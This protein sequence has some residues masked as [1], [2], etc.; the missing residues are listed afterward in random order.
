MKFILKSSLWKRC[1]LYPLKPTLNLPCFGLG[2]T[3][4]VF[5]SFKGQQSH[6]S[7]S[8]KSPF[9]PFHDVA[10]EIT[11]NAE[12]I[13][14]ELHESRAIRDMIINIFC[15]R[16]RTKK[17]EGESFSFAFNLTHTSV[18]NKSTSKISCRSEKGRICRCQLQSF[19]IIMTF[20]FRSSLKFVLEDE[21]ENFFLFIFHLIRND[22]DVLSLTNFFSL[23]KLY[24]WN[25]Y[26]SLI[27]IEL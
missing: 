14:H 25:L 3:D 2:S 9:L 7:F 26:L 15:W 13:L 1:F 17:N 11:A 5:F 6:L 27:S 21:K 19:T 18:F 8:S 20:C 10:L 22:Y 12:K 24:L 16:P 4:N 23:S